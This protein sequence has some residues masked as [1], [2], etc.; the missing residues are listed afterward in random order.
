MGSFTS[1]SIFWSCEWWIPNIQ[2]E[3]FWENCWKFFLNRLSRQQ[4]LVN[5]LVAT[6]E[7]RRRFVYILFTPLHRLIV[8]ILLCV[9]LVDT[10]STL[11]FCIT[12][13]TNYFLIIQFDSSFDTVPRIKAFIK[14]FAFSQIFR[15]FI[16]GCVF[17]IYKQSVL[18]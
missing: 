4:R 17:P 18:S 3:Y 12:R 14:F 13:Q 9:S 2:F 6:A 7:S 15:S 8:T 1:W 16:F 10:Y 11:S 5:W